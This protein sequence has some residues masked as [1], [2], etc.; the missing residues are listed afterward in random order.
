MFMKF[1]TVIE[2]KGLKFIYIFI[3]ASLPADLK[4]YLPGNIS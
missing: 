4:I 3:C 1:F 2:I